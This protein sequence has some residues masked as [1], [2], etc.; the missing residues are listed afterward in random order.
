MTQ[1]HQYEV[2]LDAFVGPLDLL[3]HLIKEY[4]IDIYDIPMSEL[5]HQY[6]SY[7]HAF[8][9]LEI[10]LASEYLVMACELIRIKSELLLPVDDDIEVDDPR[11]ELV[12]QLLEY[13]NYKQSAQLLEEKYNERLLYVSKTP[14]DLT[15]YSNSQVELSDD[16]SLSDLIISYQ[17]VKQRKKM[18]QQDEVVIYEDQYSVAEMNRLIY[19]HLDSSDREYIQFSNL[20]NVIQHINGIVTIFIAMLEM[21]K[22]Q[23][24]IIKQEKAFSEILIYRGDYYGR[25]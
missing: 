23:Q 3:L 7:I 21:I 18:I 9:S 8:E 11:E 14:M 20:A 15:P 16:L 1:N 13:D 4:E 19:N 5:T 12:E 10:N 17:R 22:H 24:I 2:Q 25:L 6:M